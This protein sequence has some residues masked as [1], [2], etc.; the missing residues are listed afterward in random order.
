MAP[1]DILKFSLIASLRGILVNPKWLIAKLINFKGNVRG[2]INSIFLEVNKPGMIS[3][4]LRWSRYFRIYHFNMP[5]VKPSRSTHAAVKQI[6]SR[7]QSCIY[8]QLKQ[9]YFSNLL[10]HTHI[11][12]ISVMY[13]ITWCY[14]VGMYKR[15][16]K[17]I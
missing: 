5:H 13:V 15:E 3:D 14:G 12:T 11:G 4:Q 1:L 9:K 2:L 10:G 16:L 7:T 17:L 6:I 8:S